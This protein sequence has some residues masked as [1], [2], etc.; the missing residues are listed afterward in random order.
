MVLV[1][2]VVIMIGMGR[3][4][5]LGPAPATRWRPA[6]GHGAHVDTTLHRLP[7]RQMPAVVH[8][9][10]LGWMVMWLLR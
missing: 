3:R 7:S 8:R 6:G 10:G 9:A 1:L 5:V 2:V 4:V